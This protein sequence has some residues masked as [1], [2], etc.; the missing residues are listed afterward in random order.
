MVY[1][2]SMYMYNAN[3][4][5]NYQLRMVLWYYYLNVYSLRA[6]LDKCTI[7]VIL[8]SFIDL[9]LNAQQLFGNNLNNLPYHDHVLFI[10]SIKPTKVLLSLIYYVMPLLIEDH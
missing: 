4:M 1:Y 5:F 6:E 8:S 9:N 10:Q 7:F 3:T 2:D